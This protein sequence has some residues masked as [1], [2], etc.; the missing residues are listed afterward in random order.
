MKNVRP[1]KKKDKKKEKVREKEKRKNNRTSALFHE[2]MSG[3]GRV[4]SN[5]T[6]GT[7]EFLLKKTRIYIRNRDPDPSATLTV[8]IEKENLDLTLP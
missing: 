5:K 2:I 1:D 3:G 8:P 4:F 6:T 7:L